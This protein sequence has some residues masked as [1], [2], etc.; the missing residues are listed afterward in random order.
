ME[1]HK[2]CQYCNTPF[3]AKKTTTKCCSDACSK[4]AYKKRKR[5]EK[6]KASNKETI[7]IINQPLEEL[8]AKEF[9]SITDASRL[10][11]VS[12]R[13]I[14]RMIDRKELPFGKFG[15]RT[16]IKRGDIDNHFNKPTPLRAKKEPKP[17]TEFYTVKEIEEKYKIK[18]GRLNTIIKNNDIP[19][20]IYNGKLKVSK[21]HIDRYFKRVRE[22]ISTITEWYTIAEAQEAY[23]LSRDQV[24]NR[25]HDNRIPKQRIGKYVRI[26]KVHFDE[27]FVIGV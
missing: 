17:I 13:T 6:I 27:L 25:V 7:S 9:L 10:L 11:G 24:Y 16:I 3:I 1:I 14:Y 12:R 20:T 22:D 15:N 18:Y 5:D 21:P 23:G 8:K 4:R 2:I 19:K 26:S